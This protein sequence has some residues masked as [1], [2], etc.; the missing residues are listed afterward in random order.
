KEILA[1][2]KINVVVLAAG[3]GT[4]MHSAKPKVLHE[5]AG[6]SLL[7]HSID[8]A[9]ALQASS[10]HVVIGHEAELLRQALTGQQVHV[11]VQQEQRGTAHAVRQ[12]LPQLDNDAIALILYGD[13]PLIRAETLKQLLAPL[14]ADSMAVLTCTVAKPG[15][16]GRIVR[17]AAG[18][19]RAIVEEKDASAEQRAI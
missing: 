10:I 2:P 8:T 17:D 16:L 19:I 12:A 6:R 7:Q 1:M 18:N 11:A 9:N 5:L 3:K 14:G 13:V 15:G 4:R